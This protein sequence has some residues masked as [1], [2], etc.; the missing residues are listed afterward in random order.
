MNNV[1]TGPNLQ[2][3]RS[4][5]LP[6]VNPTLNRYIANANADLGSRTSLAM[7][8]VSNVISG[9]SWINATSGSELTRAVSTLGSYASREVTNMTRTGVANI[10]T[11]IGIANSLNS[12][13]SRL[14]G[15]ATLQEILGNGQRNVSNH[16][17]T[18][19]TVQVQNLARQRDGISDFIFRSSSQFNNSNVN[20]S[21]A[22][23]YQSS[24]NRASNLLT[25]SMTNL[26]RTISTNYL[27][28]QLAAVNAGIQSAIT[29]FNTS[30]PVQI[31]NRNN[32]AARQFSPIVSASRDLTSYINTNSSAILEV[33][34]RNL[35]S[36]ST[37][38]TTGRYDRISTNAT[39]MIRIAGTNY[40]IAQQ[41]FASSAALQLSNLTNR[42][43]Q[44][45]SFMSTGSQSASSGSS[46][47]VM[48]Q[49]VTGLASVGNIQQQINN[50][51]LQ[52]NSDNMK[53][54]QNLTNKLQSS[55]VS[56]SNMT[57]TITALTDALS[58]AVNTDSGP[59]SKVANMIVEVT[60]N[61]NK[62]PVLVEQQASKSDSIMAETASNV[63][64]N[65]KTYSGSV[66]NTFRQYFSSPSSRGT[67][68]RSN[69]T[70]GVSSSSQRI[71]EQ[72]ASWRRLNSGIEGRSRVAGINAEAASSSLSKRASDVANTIAAVA[73]YI[74]IP[75]LSLSSNIATYQNTL[76]SEFEGIG[77]DLRTNIDL[78]SSEFVPLISA[79]DSNFDTFMTN[80]KRD[81]SD[82]FSAQ[83]DI[84]KSTLAQ[85]NASFVPQVTAAVASIPGSPHDP[86]VRAAQL[87]SYLV[88]GPETNFNKSMDLF[89]EKI[90]NASTGIKGKQSVVESTIGSTLQPGQLDDISASILDRVSDQSENL[91]L[92]AKIVPL[93]IEILKLTDPLFDEKTGLKTFTEAVKYMN[94]AKMIDS[95]K[96]DE[97]S[98]LSK[99]LLD[100]LEIQNT[101]ISTIATTI[102][103]PTSLFWEA[104]KRF[105]PS[106]AL[107]TANSSLFANYS[108]SLGADTYLST[109]PTST[110]FT[111]GNTAG[112]KLDPIVAWFTTAMDAYRSAM[113]ERISGLQEKARSMNL[114]PASYVT[115]HTS[116][117]NQILDDL[118][119]IVAESSSSASGALSEALAQFQE[120][121]NG[122]NSDSTR[123][124]TAIGSEA[125]KLLSTSLNTLHDSQTAESILEQAEMNS[126][127]ARQNSILSAANKVS[128]LA[129][130]STEA[131]IHAIETS[132][133]D[134]AEIAHTAESLPIIAGR[135]MSEWI[136]ADTA[137]SSS[138]SM[139]EPLSS[140]HDEQIEL[141]LSK[142][143]AMM[144]HAT[145]QT[146]TVSENATIFSDSISTYDG[147]LT[148]LQKQVADEYDTAMATIDLVRNG[149]T[150]DLSPLSAQRNSDP[151]SE[152]QA[153]VDDVSGMLKTVR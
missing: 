23:V 26:R 146:R 47:S 9:S 152:I 147:S 145:G 88:S 105:S 69:I 17:L 62:L 61:L 44:A 12:N 142:V 82:A 57:K 34:S 40:T 108:A 78:A 64:A 141:G 100:S 30:V 151:L 150:V 116:L 153:A 6:S 81:A 94:S 36:S 104:V 131:F 51:L 58:G 59:A 21:L 128:S 4:F 139:L 90:L 11:L 123:N 50:A 89:T 35:A 93:A 18:A 136:A 107:R 137:S 66:G 120:S 7:S 53:A 134:S 85:V 92:V 126:R 5:S 79:S 86:S 67:M 119:K 24:A 77:K 68:L 112:A 38:G 49:V 55:S 97:I 13:S 25:T 70:Q 56:F 3:L 132:V 80:S 20:P 106:A 110:I 10:N 111:F 65:L 39:Q 28:S 103:D 63:T 122:M 99:F 96:Q 117:A 76:S 1:F 73:S 115:S 109:R 101:S 75:S 52:R 29:N 144:A 95:I 8:S 54:M 71:A 60:D 124:A 140:D 37:N 149:P 125:K 138:L 74:P 118:Q 14:P 91:V 72:V 114:D 48:S 113:S 121:M 135:I 98:V 45:K 33:A 84:G 16:S 148:D 46:N 32:S 83:V 41:N 15:L 133:S 19:L 22:A 2:A 27:A 102:S 127:N 143:K 130:F 87:A 43:A 31:A 42:I 129:A